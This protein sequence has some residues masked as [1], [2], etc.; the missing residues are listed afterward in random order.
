[1]ASSS[2]TEIEPPECSMCGTEME[3][4]G[5]GTESGA[6]LIGEEIEYQRFACPDCGQGARFERKASEAEWRRAGL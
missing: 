6:P 5:S 1:M 3:F 4:R 2:V